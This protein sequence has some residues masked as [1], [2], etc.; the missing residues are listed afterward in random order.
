MQDGR[1]DGLVGAEGEAEGEAGWGFGHGG[2]GLT[3]IF[4]DFTD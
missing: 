4:T 1:D 2:K 3:P